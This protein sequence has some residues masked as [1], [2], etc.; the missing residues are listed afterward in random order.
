[1]KAETRAKIAES[2]RH[3]RESRRLVAELLASE[4][5]LLD[6]PREPVVLSTKRFGQAPVSDVDFSALPAATDELPAENG[7]PGRPKKGVTP[8]RTPYS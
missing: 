7:A 5:P 2:L 6:P 8:W 1:M 3:G 4:T